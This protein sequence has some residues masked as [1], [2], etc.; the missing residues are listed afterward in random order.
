LRRPL[1]ELQRMVAAVREA[2]PVPL[3]S[4]AT[5]RRV[6]SAMHQRVAVLGTNS[7]AVN[8]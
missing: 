1:Q 6:A 4:D 8:L 7:L 2:P 3:L 5:R